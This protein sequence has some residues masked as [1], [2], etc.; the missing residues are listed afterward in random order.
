MVLLCAGAVFRGYA[1]SSE[2]DVLAQQLAYSAQ[3]GRLYAII[4]STGS[5]SYGDRL[6]EILPADGTITATLDV[7]AGAGI[8]KT[9]SDAPVAYVGFPIA[10][11]IR[12]VDLQPFAAAPAFVVSDSLYIADIAV[13]PGTTGTIAAA[14]FEGGPCNEVALFDDGV[15]RPGTTESVCNS[16]A[17]GSSASILY[18]YDN[19]DTSYVL[20]RMAIDSSGVH[21]DDFVPQLVDSFYSTIVADGDSIYVTNGMRIDGTKL[22]LV[23]TY[24]ANGPVVVDDSIESVI[25]VVGSEVRVFDQATFVPLRSFVLAGATGQAVSASTCG[26]ACVAVAFDSGQLFILPNVGDNLFKDGFDHE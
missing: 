6:I 11:S 20:A 16:I 17:F 24:A 19:Y 8:L 21:I 1:H 22:Q 3:T 25:F 14:L 26:S 9:S 7:G 15:K 12:R 4:S 23:G 2:I 10:H 13:M 18:G 5:G